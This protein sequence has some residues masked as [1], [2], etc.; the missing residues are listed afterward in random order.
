MERLREVMK[1]CIQHQTALN[2]SFVTLLTA[3]IEYIFSSVVFQCPCSSGNMLYGFIFFLAPAFILLLL[4]YLL[5][6]RLWRVL[7]GSCS[8]E[9]YCS[10]RLKGSCAGYYKVLL[11]ETGKVLV[12]PCTWISIALLSSNFYECAATGSEWVK[13]F[14]CNKN[15]KCYEVLHEMPCN[16]TI[17][18]TF[19]K[20]F[21]SLQAQSQL[22]GWGLISGMV[23][24]TLIV[25]CFTQCCSPV[26]YHQQKFWTVYWKEEHKEFGTKAEEHAKMLAE[27]NM[28]CFFEGKRTE[29]FQ[30]PSCEAWKNIS[31]SHTF[32][33]NEQHYSTLHKY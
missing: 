27:R 5:N 6:F 13:N 32:S 14:T 22:I 33:E 30:T 3:A 8:K 7:T 21:L 25:K 28:K 15:Q 29:A 1:F 19:S 9:S 23:L 16:K 2:Y 18:N 12:A 11:R 4:G 24:L 20:E 31:S 10:C 26:G 17:K